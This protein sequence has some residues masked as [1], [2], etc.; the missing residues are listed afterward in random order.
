[1]A[2]MEPAP[3][4]LPWLGCGSRCCAQVTGF[5][6]FSPA[7]RSASAGSGSSD[8]ASIRVGSSLTGVGATSSSALGPRVGVLDLNFSR[9]AVQVHAHVVVSRRPA[10]EGPQ[11]AWQRVYLHTRPFDRTGRPCWLLPW[12]FELLRRAAPTEHLSLASAIRFSAW[13]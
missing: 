12:D 11:A 3:M 13:R 8:R 1:S 9:P 2:G 4:L 7:A 6:T 5:W 10:L